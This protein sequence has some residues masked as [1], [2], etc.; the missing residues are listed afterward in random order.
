MAI[1]EESYR[2]ILPQTNFND[3]NGKSG[4]AILYNKYNQVVFQGNIEPLQ[5]LQINTA[6]L[7]NDVY[8]LHI[9]E[10]DGKSEQR[11]IVVSK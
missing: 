2:P 1:L 7:P 4:T 8:F 3:N 6:K 9:I 5:K 11:Q 10:A